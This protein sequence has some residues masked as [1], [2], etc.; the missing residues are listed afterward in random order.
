MCFNI[1][2]CNLLASNL[3]NISNFHP[4]EVVGRI[5]ETQLQV[6]ENFNKIALNRQ[7]FLFFMCS[8]RN[9]QNY[10][11]IKTNQI[12]HTFH[13]HIFQICHIVP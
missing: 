4:L 11:L 2:I 10:F 9:L 1:T 7:L 8:S 5:S 12:Q 13:V 6:G 3:T